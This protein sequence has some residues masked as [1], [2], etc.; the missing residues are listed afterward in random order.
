[1]PILFF[2]IIPWQVILT[3]KLFCIIQQ[4]LTLEGGDNHVLPPRQSPHLCF[5]CHITSQRSTFRSKCSQLSSSCMCLD[6]YDW[7]VWLWLTGE[8][9]YAI[10]RSQR[11]QPNLFPC[12][13]A[14]D[15]CGIT[16]SISISYTVHTPI[17][18]SHEDTLACE[19]LRGCLYWSLL[20]WGKDG[21]ESLKYVLQFQVSAEAPK[22]VSWGNGPQCC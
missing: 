1:M 19:S 22:E 5:S 6:P 17:C 2:T 21:I 7:L 8:K 18:E 4:L 14:M 16:Y 13:S 10:P 12:L 3:S 11:A 9:K 15:N 20:R